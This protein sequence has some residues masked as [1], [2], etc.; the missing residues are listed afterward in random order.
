MMRSAVDLPQPDG[1]S[2]ERNSPA[3]H[4][5]IETVE[6]ERAGVERLADAAQRNDRRGRGLRHRYFRK[7]TSV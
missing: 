4:V 2:S 1:P 7:P 6:R 5:E 3:T